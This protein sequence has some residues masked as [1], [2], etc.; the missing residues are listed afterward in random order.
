[1]GRLRSFVPVAL[2]AYSFLLCVSCGGGGAPSIQPPPPPAP[3][4]SIAFSAP[5]VTLAQG[6][7]NS[8]VTLSINPLNGFHGDAQVT[9]N[10]LPTGVTAA[11][12]S[13]F[14]VSAGGS[15]SL[16]FSASS[17]ASTGSFTVSAQ[18][19][20]GALAH[21]AP[22]PMTIQ[23]G[24]SPPPSRTSYSRTDSLA[25]LDDP[26]GE[27]HHRHIVYDPT[28][29]QL[30][31]ANRAMNRVEVFSAAT[32]GRI[33][34]ISVPAAS[35]IDLSSDGKTLWVG[36]LAGQVAAVDP[37][38]LQIKSRFAVKGI[39][40]V[41]NTL[42]DRPEELVALASGKCL[43]RLR[44]PD[45]AQ[46]LLA[47]WD[48]SANS[49]SDLS[50][51]TPALFQKGVGPLAR[52]GDYSHVLV[53]A[54]DASGEIGLLDSNAALVAGPQTLNSG[55]I[56]L[57]AANT[58]ATRYA[59][60][61]SG[62]V[63][64]QLFLLDAALNQ[65]SV[66]TT[67]LPHGIAFSPD[68]KFLYLS[69]NDASN[70]V[71]TILDGHDLHLIGSVSDIAVQGGRSEIE[72]ADETQL[73]FGLIN[74][75]VSFLDAA[76]PKTLP[77]G[78]PSFAAAPALQPSQGPTLGGT[79][80]QLS[81]QNFESAVQVRFGSQPATSV[82][83]NGSTQILATSPSN[84]VPGP[85][86][87]TAYFP[88]GRLAL[89]PDAFSYGPQILQMLPN[90]AAK[91]GGDT[92]QLLGYGFGADGTQL[93]V[94]IGG[95][96]A[97]VQQVE[98]VTS[99]NLPA[100]YPFSLQRIT[101]Q[102]PPGTA[103]K[104]GVTVTAPSGMTTAAES[105]QY[106]QTSQVFPKA[107][108]YKFLLY[109]HSRQWLYLSNID[110]VDVFDL[111]AQQFRTATITPPGGPP[112]NAGLRGL[113]LTPDS[114]QLLVADFGAQKVYIFNPTSGSG[115]AVSVGGIPGFTNSGPAR[116]A[117]TSAQSAFV[118]LTG[119]GGSGAACNT[120]LAQLDLTASP[121]VV[122]PAPQPQVTALTGAP[123][124][125][126]SAAGDRVF[127]A[128]GNAPGGPLAVWDASAPNQFTFSAL[129]SSAADLAASADGNAFAA[130]TGGATELRS[131]SLTLT[132]VSALS[133]I[134]R[135][136]SSTAVPGVVLHPSGALVYQP[137]LTGPPP[138]SPPASAIRGGVDIL[139]AHSGRLR[140][141]IFL[142]E[143]LA[144][145]SSDT[146]GLHGSFL[147]IDENGQRLFALT[148]SGLTVVQLAAVP[149]GIGMLSPSSGPAIG[150]TQITIRGSGFVSGIT[151]TLGGKS[152]AVAFKDMNTLQL[153]TPVLSAGPQQIVLTNPDGESVSFDAAFTA[154]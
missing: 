82:S 104:A 47:L 23:A 117:T 49:I 39:T 102:V 141:R 46:A 30:F 139:D 41:P 71:I 153:T 107:G 137:F 123:L 51:L 124:I 85:A 48:P 73:V 65:V 63:G 61:F 140:L 149:L 56:S 83:V 8:A 42:F 62:S 129:H 76:S 36:T 94:K 15:A 22:L 17:A 100:D 138:V 52:S 3:D 40:P 122:Q 114:S 72:F 119:E 101:L 98:S 38:S 134:E 118:G 121:P 11:P 126:S 97:Q 43:V 95:A 19:S 154:N 20:S 28:R 6:T 88:S 32:Q 152:A 14:T 67:A 110:H 69:E 150:G 148:S 21:S 33:A 68:G 96:N 130:R 58:D 91:T 84:S 25:A 35:G 1:M 45:S 136:P 106:L 59:A 53:A 86:N 60:V 74:R 29:K 133:E 66:R 34:Q 37:S 90:A 143:P 55:T 92:I 7:S 146:D 2:F 93:A 50:S 44:Q 78:V 109:D 132:G 147:A 75:G 26:P 80:T 9:L 70:P 125:Q 142:P 31:A 89:A 120:C 103:G 108:F 116:V 111:A 151:A 54:A 13:P 4:F 112:P 145:L 57:V 131:A 79:A 10:N 5:S 105:L 64:T 144:M 99:L 16:V 128:F 24:A 77:S 81:G 127:L 113:A 27:P 115:S 87:V 135:I 12:A 18:A